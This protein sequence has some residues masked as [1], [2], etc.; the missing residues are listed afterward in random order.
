MLEFNAE[1]K[2]NEDLALNENE[3]LVVKCMTK[4]DQLAAAQKKV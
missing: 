1:D 4:D 2:A 3:F